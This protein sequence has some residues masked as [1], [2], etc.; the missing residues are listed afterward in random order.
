M[1]RKW[2]RRRFVGTAWTAPGLVQITLDAAPAP[3]LRPSERE[4]LLLAMDEII[5]AG[6]GMPAASAVGG[7]EYVDRLAAQVPAIKRQLG[8][9][10]ASIESVSRSRFR[11]GFARLEQS[12]RIS[13]L[14]EMERQAAPEHFR[15]LRDLVYEA[16]YTQPRVWKLLGYESHLTGDPG[17]RMKPF[18]DRALAKVRAL[19]KH[20]REVG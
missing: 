4:T 19:P 17:P 20:Y 18:D 1:K 9:V 11:R 10:L 7:L 3:V 13:A 16:Y 6:E 15:A 5:P 2:T 12:D 14:R 8:R